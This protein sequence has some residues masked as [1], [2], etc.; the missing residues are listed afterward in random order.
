MKSIPCDRCDARCC[1]TYIV[2]I[3]GVDIQRLAAFLSTP[4][5]DWCTLEPLSPTIEEYGYF[6]FRLTGEGRF[7]VCIKRE[8]GACVFFRRSTPHAACGIH[9][10]RPGMC[11]CYPVTFCSGKAEH[12]DGCIC[13][14]RWELDKTDEAVFSELYVRYNA[15]FASFKEI[16]DIWE[17]SYRNEYILSGRMTG[18]HKHDSTVFLEY[19]ASRLA[20]CC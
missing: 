17:K 11:R 6:S 13:P 4:L 15:A 20:S 19:L 12:T 14:E 7:I 10:A 9:D 1:R 8:N 16:T 18:D 5:D 3:N 2:P